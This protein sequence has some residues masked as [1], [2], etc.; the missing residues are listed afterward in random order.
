MATTRRRF[1]KLAGIA[2]AAGTL[3][4]KRT[5]AEPDSSP[6]SGPDPLVLVDWHSHVITPGE[7]AYLS[8]RTKA[9]R[10]YKDD[11]GRSVLENLTTVSAAGGRPSVTSASDIETRVKHLDENR[12]Q[13][14]LLSYTVALGYDATLPIDEL[15]PF[16]RTLN[17]DMA[18]TLRKY[19]G[20]F[21]GVAAVP[22]TDPAWA[23][24][25]LARAHQDLGLIGVALPLNAFATVE[26]ARTQARLFETAQKFG[27][28]IFV[29]RAPASTQLPG[30]PPLIV[31]TDLGAVR[32]SVISN[33]HLV[34]GAI[35]LG[36]SD[37]LDPY[38]DVTVQV[39][40]LGGFFPYLIDSIIASGP[41]LNIKDPLAR[42]RRIYLEP[43]PYSSSN[44][45]WVA[46]AAQ[47]FGADRI[48]F[49]TDYGV[50]GGTSQDRLA[51][52]VASLNK[53]LT[54]SQRQLIYVDNSR[55]LLKARGIT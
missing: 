38:P 15:R 14:Q 1:I 47:K 31:P 49:G 35:T 17:D 18:A 2:A 13:R 21:L 23:A 9:P 30:Q 22:T 7:I 50:G 16:Y 52:S 42:L 45:E 53:A 10:I 28:H 24:E 55:A 26:S 32:W 46:L 37:F 6:P 33:T 43:G 20:R 44:G 54:P 8:G 51:P 25:E 12:V 27:S 5:F 29:N 3:L 34:N 48:L 36:L 39:I 40:M 41:R 11:Q 19:P 4:P